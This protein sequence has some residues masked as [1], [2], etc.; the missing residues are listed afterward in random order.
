MH[1]YGMGSMGY[2]R[3]ETMGELG[4]QIEHTYLLAGRTKPITIREAASILTKADD[5]F[6]TENIPFQPKGKFTYTE[7]YNFIDL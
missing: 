3:D 4:Y 1:V 5:Y 2:N 6:S 7:W